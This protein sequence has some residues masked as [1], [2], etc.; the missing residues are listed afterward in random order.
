MLGIEVGSGKVTIDPHVP[1][2]VGRVF[3]HGMHAFESHW[4]VDA[5]GDE[6]EVRPTT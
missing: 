2:E 6:G 3:V 4:D 5:T 1:K